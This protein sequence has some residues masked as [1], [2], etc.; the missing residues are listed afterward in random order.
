VDDKDVIKAINAQRASTNGTFDNIKIE[1]GQVWVKTPY[2]PTAPANYP[3]KDA[4]DDMVYMATKQP[5]E[6]G[7]VVSQ[8]VQRAEGTGFTMGFDI[9]GGGTDYS[10][11]ARPNTYRAWMQD[12]SG[13][14]TYSNPVYQSSQISNQLYSIQAQIKSYASAYY[15]KQKDNSQ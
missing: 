7:R 9:I 8:Q 15:S 13:K 14:K 1:D 2:L 3:L 12:P 4:V 11:R 6:A 10:G 5:I